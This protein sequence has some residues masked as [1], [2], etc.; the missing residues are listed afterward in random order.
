MSITHTLEQ[1]YNYVGGSEN[2]INLV[3]DEQT[4]GSYLEISEAIPDNSTDLEVAM[5]MDVSEIALVLIT[6]DR[7]ITFKTNSSSVPDE[8]ITVDENTPIAWGSGLSGSNPLETDIT[9]IFI[10]NNVDELDA[11]LKVRVLYDPTP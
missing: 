9:A 3:S 2:L 11:T 6:C 5:V 4:A 8:T 10:T 1:R 7:E